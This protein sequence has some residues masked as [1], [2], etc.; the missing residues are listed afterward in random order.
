MRFAAAGAGEGGAGAGPRLE[1]LERRLEGLEALLGEARERFHAG[2]GMGR[3]WPE[4]APFGQGWERGWERGWDAGVRAGE[5]CERPE[6]ADM[7]GAV[8]AEKDYD[9]GFNLGWTKGWG[10]GWSAG[11]ASRGE[12]CP[13]VA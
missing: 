9:R 10:K 3:S 4:A 13:Q 5:G 6:A 11:A 1:A 7:G 2:A 12:P 8:P